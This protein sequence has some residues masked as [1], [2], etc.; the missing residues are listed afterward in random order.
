MTPLPHAGIVFPSTLNA[1]AM[2]CPHCHGVGRRTAGLWSDPDPIVP[3]TKLEAPPPFDRR[4]NPCV[5]RGLFAAIGVALIGMVGAVVPAWHAFT[6]SAGFAHRPG[7]TIT[8]GITLIGFGI[9][10]QTVASTDHPPESPAYRI[11]ANAWLHQWTCTRCDA[12]WNPS[13]AAIQAALAAS[14]NASPHPEAKP[15]TPSV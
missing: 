13:Q 3:R 5:L 15:P 14:L 1:L 2:P 8:T 9:G 4:M 7:V 10:I 6:W 12:R 11:A